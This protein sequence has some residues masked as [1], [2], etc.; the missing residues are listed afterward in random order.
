MD[1]H[2]RK[3][4][5]TSKRLPHLHI[6]GILLV[7]CG[8]SKSC[9]QSRP[10]NPFIYRELA[11]QSYERPAP[12]HW[13]PSEPSRTEN[14]LDEGQAAKMSKPMDEYPRQCGKYFPLNAVNWIGC[15]PKITPVTH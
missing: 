2:T 7:G 14:E 1:M 3:L 8:F 5:D 4:S 12:P 15:R 11:M 9:L 6:L 13:R 10:F